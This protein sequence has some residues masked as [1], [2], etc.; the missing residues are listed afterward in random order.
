MQPSTDHFHF[1]DSSNYFISL[2]FYILSTLL[3]YP[4][5]I[6]LSHKPPPQPCTQKTKLVFGAMKYFGLTGTANTSS[7]L[8]V[9]APE[10]FGWDQTDQPT[11]S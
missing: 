3:F 1:F 2:G 9:T 5:L 8:W 10:T 4:E 6:F 7:L 11:W